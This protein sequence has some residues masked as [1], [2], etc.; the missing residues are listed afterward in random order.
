[1]TVFIFLSLCCQFLGWNCFFLKLEDLSTYNIL[2]R[3][4][5]DGY[6][7]EEDQESLKEKNY[8]PREVAF[9]VYIDEEIKTFHVYIDMDGY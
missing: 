7:T 3:R 2:F 9:H 8:V 6:R 4:S 1:M 5:S